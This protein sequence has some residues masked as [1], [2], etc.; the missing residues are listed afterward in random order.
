[1]KGIGIYS[2]GAVASLKN[3]EIRGSLKGLSPFTD[4]LPLSLLR[5]GGYRG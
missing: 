5:R 3:P 2:R 4:H 1:L